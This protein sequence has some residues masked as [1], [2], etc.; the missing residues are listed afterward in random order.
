MNTERLMLHELRIK[1]IKREDRDLIARLAYDYF[2]NR[3]VV[4]D[5]DLERLLIDLACM[6]EGCFIEYEELE[7]RLE[8]FFQGD[9]FIYDRLEFA[10]ELRRLLLQKASMTCLADWAYNVW[11]NKNNR[12]KD[13]TIHDIAYA[14]SFMCCHEFEYSYEELEEIADRLMKGEDVKL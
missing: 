8:Y 13:K 7:D 6:Q 11:F 3:I 1:I 10:K 5:S 14:L 4:V 12:K 9:H 2:Q